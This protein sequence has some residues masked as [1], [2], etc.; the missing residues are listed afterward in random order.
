MPSEFVFDGCTWFPDGWWQACC[1]LHDYA[2]WWQPA[3]ITLEQWNDAMTGCV[4]DLG[5]GTAAA[6]AGFGLCKVSWIFWKRGRRGEPGTE[7]PML[8]RW[9]EGLKGKD[10][11]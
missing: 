6:I 4:S 2:F 1:L 9:A 3:G 8:R 5:A 7:P 11:A 10:T